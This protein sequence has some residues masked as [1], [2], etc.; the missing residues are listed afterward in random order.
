M[1]KL[2]E[3]EGTRRKL[4]KR[5]EALQARYGGIIKQIQLAVDHLGDRDLSAD[6][7][8]GR[9]S[10]IEVKPG[11][12]F[13]NLPAGTFVVCCGGVSRRRRGAPF[14]F[15]VE[16]TKAVA[17]PMGPQDATSTLLPKALRKNSG[18]A[19]PPKKLQ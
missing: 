19:V 4:T 15:L 18:T 13:E 11:M 10:L 2:S 16:R 5:A 3:A 6:L 8:K 12:V 14:T 9:V 17:T 7:A 1:S